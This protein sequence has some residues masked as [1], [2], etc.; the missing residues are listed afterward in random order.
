MYWGW[1]GDDQNHLDIWNFSHNSYLCSE[2]QN[3]SKIKSYQ[4]SSCSLQRSFIAVAP[5]TVSGKCRQAALLARALNGKREALWSL[6]HLEVRNRIYALFF[7]F[8]EFV[9]SVDWNLFLV[10]VR[11]NLKN[12][13]LVIY[14]CKMMFYLISCILGLFRIQWSFTLLIVIWFADGYFLM[15]S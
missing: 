13:F 2:V 11:I 1:G 4:M 15:W 8:M 7:V 12:E 5:L 10:L 6:F 14:F 3:D 9:R